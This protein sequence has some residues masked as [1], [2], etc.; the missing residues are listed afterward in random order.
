LGISG[1]YYLSAGS[2]DFVDNSEQIEIVVR[3]RNQP[4]IVLQRTAVTRFVDYTVEPLTR[5]ILFTRAI[6]SVDANLN[7]Q[8]IRVTYE[9]DSGGPKFTV[10][11]TDVQ[12]KITD[13]VQLGV[14]AST[15]ENP[16][17]A[18]KLQA[19]TGLARIGENATVAGELVGTRSDEQGEGHGARVEARYQNEKLAAVALAAKTSNGFDNPGASFSAGQTQASARAEYRVDP[20]LAVRAETLYGKDSGQ[21]DER[22]GSTV[23]VQ[24]KLSEQTVAEV[25]LRHGQG[26][27]ALAANSG[28]DY[29]QISTY[30]GQLGG[31]IGANSVTTLGAAAAANSVDTQPDHGART[32]VDAGA[33]RAECAGLH[34]GRAG[35]R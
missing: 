8:S 25:G 6:S 21:T 11:G 26:N 13:A 33:R 23:S 14:V 30:D 9:I 16:Q 1:P 10:A 24:K 5:R 27:G 4:D 2:G 32:A 12:V 3:D 29:G 35:H 28:F 31:S 7:P 22:K 19:I 17:N 15:D 34:R 20:S 18:R